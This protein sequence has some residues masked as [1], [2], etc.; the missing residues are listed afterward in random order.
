MAARW[1]ATLD[2]Y[3]FD[4]EYR[5][6]SQHGNSDAVSRRPY[7]KCKRD[8]CTECGG[9]G[10]YEPVMVAT[11]AQANAQKQTEEH[12]ERRNSQSES[13]SPL[14]E[15]V[16]LAPSCGPQ[17]EGAVQKGGMLTRA[18][19]RARIQEGDELVE[20]ERVAPPRGTPWLLVLVQRDR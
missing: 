8:S 2:T 7:R 17:T 12:G 6:G 20:G 9:L 19:T 15:D 10:E 5:K 3:D 1:I 16:S 11:R 4:S 13:A 14:G 18:M